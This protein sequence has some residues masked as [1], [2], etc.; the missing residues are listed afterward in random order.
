MT[1][2]KPTANCLEEFRN[3]PFLDN[4]K[5]VASLSMSSEDKKL[6]WWAAHSMTLPNWSALDRH[7]L[8]L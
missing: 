8:V 4:D 3:F 5:I 6:A 1:Y 2:L 7:L